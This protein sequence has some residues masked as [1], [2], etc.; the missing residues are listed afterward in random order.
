VRLSRTTKASLIAAVLAV[1]ALGW[2]G[3]RLLD[4]GG[5]FD[6]VAWSDPARMR[7]G[8]R[9]AMADRFIARRTLQGMTRSEVIK[10]LGE[11]SDEGYFKEWDLVY[12]LGPERGFM[13]VDF[14]MAGLAART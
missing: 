6:P 8:V 1:F 3:W 13:S 11:P 10:R 2:V 7:Q 14:G 4:H 5:R 12:W 9:L